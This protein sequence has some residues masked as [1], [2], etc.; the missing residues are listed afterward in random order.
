MDFISYICSLPAEGET[1]LVVLQK[2]VGREIQLHADGA[3]KA[4]WPAFLPSH[5][6]KTGAWYGNTASFIVDRFK[7]GHP[8]ASAANCEFVLVMV[9]D[10]VGTDKVPNTCPL[11]PTWIMETSPGSFQWGYAFSEQPRKGDFAAAIKA[12]AEAGYTDK[13]AINAVRNFR[14]P[15]SISLKP[16]RDN[17][18]AVLVEFNPSREYTLEELCTAMNVTPGPVESVYAPVR[19]ADDGGDDVMAWLSEN[20]LVLSNPNQEGW[21]GVA[22]PNSAEHTDGNPEGRYMPANR[23]Y[24]CLHSH[25]LELDSSTFLKWVAD[26]GG[27]V[28]APGLRDEL[29]VST[30]ESALSKLTPTPDFPNVAAAVVAET[31]RKEMARV[32]KADWWDRFAYLQDD[33]AYFDLQDRREISRSTFNAMFRHIG[34]K[35]VHNGRKVI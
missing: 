9:L 17:F 35:S 30:M 28:H 25:C 1:A 26:S 12:I 5:K 4:T 16:G 22:C 24:C 29:L 20:G 2:P 18:A 34:C 23:A 13:G 10:D 32:E 31:Q 21:A 14:L 6:M 33:D 3:I 11:P 27:P 8:S 19:V 7:D 15:G